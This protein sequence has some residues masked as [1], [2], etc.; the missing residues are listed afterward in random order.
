MNLR[1]QHQAAKEKKKKLKKKIGL[2]KTSIDRKEKKLRIAE[3][4]LETTILKIRS[5]KKQLR[6]LAKETKKNEKTSIST[7]SKRLK[8]SKKKESKKDKKAK[9]QSSKEVKQKK[10]GPKKKAMV[11]EMSNSL[12]KI[13][14]TEKNLVKIPLK[15]L[16]IQKDTNK[17]MVPVYPNKQD[18]KVIDGIGAKI[19]TILNESG[20]LTFRQLS[21]CSNETLDHLLQQNFINWRALNSLTWP[22]QAL[23][24]DAGKFAELE[25]FK[26]KIRNPL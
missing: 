12:E 19:E 21:Q 20:I 25:K 4:K 14:K 23:L 11:P 7:V 6:E 17:N 13:K 3:K 8:A 22:E 2:L 9:D 10:K 16:T 15:S 24:A 5:F 18:L 1:E 26:E